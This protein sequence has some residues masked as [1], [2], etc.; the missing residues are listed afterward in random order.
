MQAATRPADASVAR[1]RYG[2]GHGER[3][4][5][6]EVLG[7]MLAD[8]LSEVDVASSVLLRGSRQQAHRRLASR[9]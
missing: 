1:R 8:H 9:M 2:G 6:G 7:R 5:H 3:G 4:Q